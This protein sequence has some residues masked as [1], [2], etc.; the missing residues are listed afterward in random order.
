MKIDIYI[1]GLVLTAASLQATACTIL[2]QDKIEL[3]H[4][5]PD[6][7]NGDR[8]AL[9]RHYLTARGWTG[10][11]T[12]ATVEATAFEYES[13]AKQLAAL[14]GEKI[15]AFL[16]QLGLDKDDIDVDERVIKLNKGKIDPDDKWQI[17]VEFV[18]KCA[19]A[20]CQKLCNTPNLPGGVSYAVTADTP[21]PVPGSNIFTCGDKREPANARIITRQVWTATTK[22]QA[23]TLATDGG[24]P[25]A[26]VCYRISTS[27][28]KYIGMTDNQ[29][30][31]ELLQLL[32]PEYTTIE[33]KVD[34]YSY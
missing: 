33:V 1:L 26:G 22:E 13:N 34:Q 12:R 23:L 20:D 4:G 18:P 30:R 19:A 9:T 24:K 14:R 10:E 32:G 5:A 11:G 29:G 21:G 15:T 31:T 27:V 17:G 2:L 3:P 25:R 8:L 7:S 16:K 28:H 6:I